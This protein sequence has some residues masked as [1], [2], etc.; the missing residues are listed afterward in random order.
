LSKSLPPICPPDQVSRELPYVYD[1]WKRS[2]FEKRRLMLAV[3]PLYQEL[4]SVVRRRML[5]KLV[6]RLGGFGGPGKK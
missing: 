2:P 6:F 4:P 5:S 3:I 1:P